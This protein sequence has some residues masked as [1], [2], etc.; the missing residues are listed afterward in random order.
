[1]TDI[2]SRLRQELPH[3]AD[4]FAAMNDHR[5]EAAD[6]IERLEAEN[7]RLREEL[8]MERE[9]NLIAHYRADCANAEVEKLRAELAEARDKALDDAQEAVRNA[10]EGYGVSLVRI[11]DAIRNLKEQAND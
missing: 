3:H 4:S 7:A 1:M 10:W 8:E 6:H 9:R 5:F 11:N 2:V